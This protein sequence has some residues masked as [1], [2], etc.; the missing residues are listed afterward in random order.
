MTIGTM[1]AAYFDLGVAA[2]GPTLAPLFIDAL[3]ARDCASLWWMEE[4]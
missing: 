2:V 1:I 3:L 4:Q